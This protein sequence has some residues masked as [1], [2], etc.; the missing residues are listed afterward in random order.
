[1][2]TLLLLIVAAWVAL[3][4]VAFVCAVVQAVLHFLPTAAPW[5]V[6]PWDAPLAPTLAQ[7]RRPA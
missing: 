5:A 7:M 4:A 2:T 6:G 3:I 1:M